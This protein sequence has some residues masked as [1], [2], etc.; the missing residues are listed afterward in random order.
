MTRIFAPIFTFG[1][2]IAISTAK[3]NPSSLSMSK[4]YT[5]LS[6][7]ALLADPLLTL[8]MA[9]MAFVGS[10]GSFARIQEFLQKEAHVDCRQKRGPV[11]HNDRIDELK[12]PSDFR[13]SGFVSHSSGSSKSLKRAL[14]IPSDVFAVQGGAFGWDSEK[15][16]ILNNISFTIPRS[17]FTMLI[18]PSGC[19][20]STFLKALLGEVPCL[21]G[22]V[23]FKVS[24]TVAYCDQTLWHLNGTIQDSII[25]MSE[26]DDVWY[27]TV[28]RACALDEDLH[29]L[30]RGDKT[31]IGSNGISL[32]GGQSQRIVLSPYPVIFPNFVL[33][34]STHRRLR[35]PYM[36]D[37]TLLS[38]TTY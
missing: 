15:E 19:G 32:S 25:A 34:M 30:P 14:S 18:G 9:L 17:S 12:K 31:V 21:S 36:P 16:P 10:V 35:G 38:W 24:E 2:Y 11:L 22:C 27:A 4:V 1:I 33:I 5:S 13:D 20:K 6:L 8:V 23:E 26:L 3:G 28:I 7:F 37:G 29:Q